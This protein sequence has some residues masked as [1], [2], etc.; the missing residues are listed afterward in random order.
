ML[1]DPTLD[2]GEIEAEQV[3][4]LIHLAALAP[5][6]EL[7][8][9]RSNSVRLRRHLSRADAKSLFAAQLT[10]DQPWSTA[11]AGT[12]KPK[13]DSPCRRRG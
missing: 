6:V 2:A 3:G 4:C 12:A 10:T 7:A 9:R 11:P 1:L 5:D 8:R 13:G